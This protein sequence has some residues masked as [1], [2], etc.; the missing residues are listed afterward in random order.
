MRC[1]PQNWGTGG[2]DKLFRPEGY[3]AN[4]AWS[5]PP[6]NASDLSNSQFA[7]DVGFSFSKSCFGMFVPVLRS[8]TKTVSCEYLPG[9]ASPV[10]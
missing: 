6:N 4:L 9:V 7:V 2:G 8:Q 1:F 3:S 5:N 10:N